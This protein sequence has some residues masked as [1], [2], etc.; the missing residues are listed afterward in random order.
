MADVYMGNT[1][2]G[3]AKQTLISNLVQRELAFQSIL[4]NTVTD[5]SAFA[6]KGVKSISFPKLTGFSVVD[7][8]EGVKGET[9]SLTATVDSINLDINAYVS[10][11]IDAFTA[12]QITIDGQIESIKRASAAVARS[13]DEAIIAKL[14]A[15][16]ASFINVGADVD[17]TYANLVDMRKTLLKADAVLANCV[18]VVSPAQEAALLKL[19]EF[20]S[21]EYYGNANV[22]MG[23]VG[24]ILGMPVFVHNGLADKQLFMYEKSAIAVGFSKEAEYGEE[25]FLGLGV[26]AKRC[27]IDMY[28][29]LGAMQ[30]ALKGAAAGKSPLIIGLN[31]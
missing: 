4:R 25:S 9:T 1:E 15:T 16:A 11:A 13:I 19:T 28:W 27:A 21:N 31:D 6:V 20:K 23:Q 22:P 14:A 2:L 18:V 29:G 7:R 10:W 12:K 26:G 3:A 5:V 17:V 30:I 8:T 24:M